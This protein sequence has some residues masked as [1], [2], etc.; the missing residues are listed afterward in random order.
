MTR[1]SGTIVV[2]SLLE[3]HKGPIFFEV[4]QS[5]RS[6]ISVSVDKTGVGRVNLRGEANVRVTRSAV[7]GRRLER[8]HERFCDIQYG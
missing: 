8:R 6:L 3:Q 2:S 1:D 7:F 5:W 4:E